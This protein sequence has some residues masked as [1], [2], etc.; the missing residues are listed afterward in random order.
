MRAMDHQQAVAGA[1]TE[2]YLLDELDEAEREAFE[3]HFFECEACAED[4]KAGAAVVDGVRESPAG[5]GAEG[6]RPVRWGLR[7]QF[8][9]LPLG[10][11]AALVLSLA[12]VA[13]QD[14]RVIPGLRRELQEADSLQAPASY[15]LYASRAE[16][17][18]VRVP[19]GGRRILVR[20][21]TTFERPF[22]GYRCRV[23]DA[24]GRTL[25]AA[26]IPAPPAGE[27]LQIQLPVKDLPSGPYEI[28]LDGLAALDGPAAAPELARYRFELR[29]EKE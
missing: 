8:W 4:L 16:P 24:G 19:A 6:P 9:P 27:E 23:R 25:Q 20:L 18:V 12:W 1:L 13:Y 15:F 11:A 17:Q 21:S 5:L 10:A 3:A 29:H 2:R 7:A 14:V 26:A 28:V 22:E